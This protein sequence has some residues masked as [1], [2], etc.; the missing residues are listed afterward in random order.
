METLLI[1]FSPDYRKMLDQMLALRLLDV[2]EHGDRLIAVRPPSYLLRHP[3]KVLWFIHHH[4]TVYDLWGTKYQDIP[5]TPEGHTYRDAIIHADNI[6]LREAEKI[7]SNSKVVACRLKRFNQ[8]DARVLYPPIWAPERFRSGG[9][10]DYMLYLSR[11]TDHKRQ[12]LAVEA[13]RHTRTPVKLVIAGAPDPE[14]EPYLKQIRLRVQE[15][16]LDERVTI[17]PRWVS[18]HEKIDLFAGCLAAIYM[19][20]DEDSYGYP[21]LEAHHSGKAVI[22]STDSG[23]TNELIVDGENGLIPEPDPEAIARAMDQLYDDRD[24]ARRMGA[25]GKERISQ[26]GISWDTALDSLLS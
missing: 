5:P 16:S 12:L 10:G 8:V 2:S 17:I 25:A 23:G 7:F 11:I 22:T 15:C 1:P 6:A 18:D 4:R 26:L 24:L 20:F 21:S 3:R 14:A 19:P 13:V 9:S